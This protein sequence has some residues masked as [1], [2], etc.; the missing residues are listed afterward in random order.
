M[1]SMVEQGVRMLLALPAPARGEE[2]A[3]E[4]ELR[5]TEREL[6]DV[7]SR[8]PRVGWHSSLVIQKEHGSSLAV[9]T[10]ALKSLA[11]KGLVYQWGEGLADEVNEAWPRETRWGMRDPVEVV[12]TWA[13]RWKARGKPQRE[14]PPALIATRKMLTGA[15]P[16]ICRKCEA[17]AMEATG[18]PSITF[19]EMTSGD[20]MMARLEAR[21]KYQA[22]PEYAAEKA[23]EEEAFRAEAVARVE[24]EKA[25]DAEQRRLDR[26]YRENRG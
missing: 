19:E 17:I 21:A 14:L 4:A 24:A 7:L 15:F 10:K 2:D 16:E 5:A 9:V 3:P 22:S 18:Y 1:S 23:A 13:T 12:R 8:L 6:L 26:E 11:R 25:H 20:A